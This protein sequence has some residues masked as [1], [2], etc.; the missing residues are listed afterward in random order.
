MRGWRGNFNDQY[1]YH[2]SQSLSQSVSQSV[3]VRSCR[4][5]TA[6]YKLIM[7]PH[8]PLR[9]ISATSNSDSFTTKYTWCLFSI[10]QLFLTQVS[11]Y[12][13]ADDTYV[14]TCQRSHLMLVVGF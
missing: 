3:R 12:D 13:L 2:V 7:I 1:L 5:P 11:F 4:L 8:C 9:L 6:S 10:G 14:E